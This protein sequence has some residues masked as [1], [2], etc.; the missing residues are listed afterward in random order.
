ML[1][2]VQHY[3]ANDSSI[4]YLNKWKKR[5]PIAADRDGSFVSMVTASFIRL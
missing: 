1:M 5:L 2:H 4:V 3:N